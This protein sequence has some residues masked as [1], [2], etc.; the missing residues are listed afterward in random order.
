MKVWIVEIGEPL[1][2]EENVRLH[3]YG[4][5]SKYLAEQGHEVTWWTSSFSHA[6]KKHLVEEDSV[7]VVD[8]VELRLIKGIGYSRNISLSRIQHQKHFAEEFFKQAEQL[9]QSNNRPDIIMAPI[10]TVDGAYAAVTL[11]KKHN[12]AVIADVRDL[13]PDEIRDLAPVPLRG[14]AS[15]FLKKSYNKMQ[16]VC[17]NA[18]CIVGVSQSYLEYGL[19]QAGRPQSPRDFVFPLGYQIQNFDKEQKS[20]AEEWWKGLNVP[21]QAFKIC[22]FGTIGKFFDLDTVLEAAKELG[23]DFYF[24]LGGD[25]SALE[26]YQNKSAQM[27]L[28]N[29]K[30]T[31]WLKGPQI[32]L[33][34]KNSQAGLAPYSVD[35]KMSLPNKPFEY[36]SAGLPVISSIQKE[37]KQILVNHEAGL[38]YLADS[39]KELIS[40][41]LKLKH[42]PDLCTQMGRNSYQLFLKEF[43][44]ERVF[45]KA[46][47]K[48]QDIVQSFYQK[49]TSESVNT[50]TS[51]SQKMEL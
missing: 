14:L 17:K 26:A 8:G 44:T 50:L 18:S 46:T 25:G 30:F 4:N 43:T 35:A 40:S 36:M 29:V 41:I 45:A 39:K 15:W 23:P 51:S 3:R 32:Q 6:I 28:K 21:S 10:P 11:G 47:D 37:L 2:L 1:P 34:M 48:L 31:G 33:V 9:I 5:Y 19:A 42:N 22:F 38:T 12:I 13:W 49:K 27:G 16:Y 20:K 7:K 24:V